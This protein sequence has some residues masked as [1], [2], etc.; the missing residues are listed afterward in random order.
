MSAARSASDLS[1]RLAQSLW[2]G[3]VRDVVLAPGESAI[4][5]ISWV[6]VAAISPALVA[7][8]VLVPAVATAL[9]LRKHLKV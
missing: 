3:G 9:S 5:Y 6:D 8:G 4:S 2:T 1:L 7:G